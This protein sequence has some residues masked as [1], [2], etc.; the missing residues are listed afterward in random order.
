MC[1]TNPTG[2]FKS[3]VALAVAGLLAAAPAAAQDFT[4]EEIVVTAQKREQSLSD[5]PLAVSAITG[6]AVNDYLGGA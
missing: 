3:S 4:L 2:Y 1:C 5:V 6:D